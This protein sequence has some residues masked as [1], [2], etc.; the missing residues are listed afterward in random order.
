MTDEQIRVLGP[1]FSSYLRPYHSFC[2]QDRTV[3]HLDAYCRALLTDAPRK[4]A[5]PNALAS[6]TAV[7]TLQKFLTTTHWDPHAVRDEFQTR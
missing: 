6:G 7:R 3:P 2:N 4:T 5:E 1:A